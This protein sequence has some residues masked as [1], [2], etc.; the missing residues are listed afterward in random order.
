MMRRWGPSCKEKAAAVTA[1]VMRKEMC[2]AAEKGVNPCARSCASAR[3]RCVLWLCLLFCALLSL[4]LAAAV[5]R[6][7]LFWCLGVL[8]LFL[9]LTSAA[10][11]SHL[12]PALS[13]V[14]SLR[15]RGEDVAR[16][17]T[18]NSIKEAR[19]RELKA[20]LLNST[21]LKVR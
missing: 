9:S 12:H 4:L 11:I 5:I 13:Q 2:K 17:I 3:H 18:R 15:Y 7:G 16:S 6:S 21:K 10:D 20:E 1:I 8:C 19:Q 14:E